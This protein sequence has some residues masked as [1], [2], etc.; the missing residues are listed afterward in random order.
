[1]PEDR[2]A[3]SDEARQKETMMTNHFGGDRVCGGVYWSKQAGEFISVPSE[4][5]RLVGTEN[6]QYL[7]MPLPLVLIA[8]PLMGLAF[9]FFLPLSGMLVLAP[10]LASKL[11][12]AFAPGAARMA[13]PQLQP[14]V[15]Y[16]EAAPSSDNPDTEIE[17]KDA[18]KLIRLAEAIAEK[19]MNEK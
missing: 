15:S 2:A 17:G 10:L 13:T 12:G 18:E 9:A 8:G 1:M 5:G 6:S 4:G 16:L 3:P 14:G 11:R 19:R 7:K